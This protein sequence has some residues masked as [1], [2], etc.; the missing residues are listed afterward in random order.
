MIIIRGQI[1]FIIQQQRRF[2]QYRIERLV[3]LNGEWQL[4]LI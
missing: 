4:R 3:R 2:R 1:D